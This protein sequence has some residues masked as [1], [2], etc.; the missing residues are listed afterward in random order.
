MVVAGS[1]GTHFTL[2]RYHTDGRLDTSLDGDGKVSTNFG[3]FGESTGYGRSVVLQADGKIIV[4]GSVDNALQYNNFALARYNKDGNLDTS[5]DDYILDASSE[6]TA[7]FNS[8]GNVVGFTPSTNTKYV[9]PDGK[10]ITDFETLVGYSNGLR[11]ENDLGYSVAVQTD[12]KVVVAGISNGNFA[13]TR[14]SS[15]GSLDNTFGTV[16]NFVFWSDGAAVATGTDN[17]GNVLFLSERGKVTTDFGGNDIAYS[18]ITQAD[19]TILVAGSSD[20]QFALARY[21]SNGSLDTTFDTDG[22]VTTAFGS[23][24]YGYSMAQQA[25]GKIIMVGSSDGQFALARYNTNGSLDTTFDGDGKA[26]TVFDGAASAASVT[27]QSD[28]KILVA[29]TITNTTGQSDFALARY[30]SNGSLDSTFSPQ[31]NTLD[32]R[33]TYAEPSTTEASVP[34]VLDRTVHIFD[35]ELAK[36]DNYAGATLI[37]TRQGGANV[38]DVF[39][40]AANS[41]LSALQPGLALKV[42][43]A[44]IG[45]VIGNALGK[46]E[47]KFNA[48]ASQTFLDKALSNI[49][50]SNTSDAPPA[51]ATIDWVFNDG[52]T[53]AQGTGG[54]LGVTGQTVVKIT[55]QNDAPVLNINAIVPLVDQI[56]SAEAPFNYTLAAD[57]FTDPDLDVLSYSAM[58]N[59][60][61]LLPLWLN[62]DPL[63]RTLSGTPMPSNVGSLGVRITATDSS[64][65]NVSGT[66]QLTIRQAPTIVTG[67]TTNDSL[68]S[69]AADEFFNAGAGI[70][71]VVFSGSRANYTLSRISQTST[72]WAINSVAEGFDK[73]SEVERLKFT[74]T[75]FALDTN[76]NAGQAYRLYQATFDRSPDASGL[77]YWI[78]YL[79]QKHTLLEAA[80]LFVSSAEF[81]GLYGE[82]PTHTALI[83]QFYQNTLHRQPEK[84]GLDF[85]VAELDSARQTV[86]QVLAG[87]SESPEN[88]S[89]LVGVIGNGFGYTPFGG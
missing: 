65:A 32:N 40:A 48:G 79:D 63:T 50:Y 38:E 73:L 56:L 87:F 26:T 21:T 18:V 64:T 60:G 55:A 4:A 33:P 6:R 88:Q 24:V 62:F 61:A 13:L 83:T 28:G 19:G 23:E 51:S 78:G 25:D 80:A 2:A 35:A 31:E 54:A 10:V 81:K 12:G 52:N 86:P 37:L 75:A 5:F 9:A 84:A 46:L 8:S 29:G 89:N 7:V 66:V 39:S 3:S 34:V 58:T 77:G 44:S 27:V 41:G 1:D 22:K 45:S 69:T 14:Y 70:D 49:A 76:G 68:K 43:G 82:S 72:D 67:T 85:W 59:D 74:D 20:N 42:D 17:N 53:T 30:N 11:P 57:I 47:I 36:L 15:S 71:T 16:D